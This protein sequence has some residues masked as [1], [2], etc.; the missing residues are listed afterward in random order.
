MNI[1]KLNLNT[2]KDKKELLMLSQFTFLPNTKTKSLKNQLIFQVILLQTEHLFNP[3]LRLFVKKFK[4]KI[5]MKSEKN[6]NLYIDQSKKLITIK[7]I[8]YKYLLITYID[9]MYI[10]L[11]YKEKMLILEF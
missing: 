10:N 9:K 7:L 1:L 2:F 5:Q 11:L 3:F 8:M 4:F 6:F